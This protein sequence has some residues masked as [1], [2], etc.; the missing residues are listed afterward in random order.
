VQAV[1]QLRDAFEIPALI[2][3]GGVPPARPQ[4]RRASR[5]ELMHKPVDPS[6]LH[7]TLREA[8]KRVR[9]TGRD[10]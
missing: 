8:L 6:A 10:S 4:E 9:G 3:T 7:E 1:E 5:Y 2:I